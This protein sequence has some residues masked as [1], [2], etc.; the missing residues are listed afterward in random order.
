MNEGGGTCV[1]ECIR[2][3]RAESVNKARQIDNGQRQRQRQR[4]TDNEHQCTHLWK[5]AKRKHAQQTGLAAGSIAYYH[6]LS[7]QKHQ[8]A[9]AAADG[10]VL[11]SAYL[12]MTFCVDVD[13]MA[14]VVVVVVL[15]VVLVVFV[16]GVII[17]SIVK[18]FC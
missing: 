11:L 14:A 2:S 12:R 15:V 17:V 18:T 4:A 3:S 5:V 6:Q 10:R 1:T 13:A 9:A 7:V 8:S 16:S